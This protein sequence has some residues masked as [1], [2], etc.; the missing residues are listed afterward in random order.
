MYKKKKNIKKFSLVYIN[1]YIFSVP[2]KDLLS[3][4]ILELGKVL[5]DI[6]H[7]PAPTTV[8]SIL[9]PNGQVIPVNFDGLTSL[10]KSA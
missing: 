5:C 4:G 9:Y 7:D 8:C 6:L 3:V 1:F 2:S 10:P